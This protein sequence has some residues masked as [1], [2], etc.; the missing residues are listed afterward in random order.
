MKQIQLQLSNEKQNNWIK[1]MGSFLLIILGDLNTHEVREIISGIGK[2][3]YHDETNDIGMKLL[4]LAATREMVI[5]SKYFHSIDNN[6][7]FTKSQ[8]HYLLCNIRHVSSVWE[9]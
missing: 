9:Q 4:S 8:F 1:R 6:E 3:S 5:S 2:Q 7:E